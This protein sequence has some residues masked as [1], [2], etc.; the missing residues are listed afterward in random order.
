MYNQMVSVRSL[1]LISG[2]KKNCAPISAETS[3]FGNTAWCNFGK[4]GHMNVKFK[5]SNSVAS[6]A[7]IFLCL[8]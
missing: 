7:S 3:T 1:L 5:L 6:S 8:Y 2:T 4:V